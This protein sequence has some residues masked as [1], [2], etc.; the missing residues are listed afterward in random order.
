MSVRNSD[1][2]RVITLNRREEANIFITSFLDYLKQ[3][4]IDDE[5]DAY[6]HYSYAKEEE[7][8]AVG[9]T[10]SLLGGLSRGLKFYLYRA[11]ERV[12]HHMEK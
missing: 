9:R 10:R 1:S 7:I 11:R 3:D 2:K 12:L 6:G 4:L 8:I 5:K